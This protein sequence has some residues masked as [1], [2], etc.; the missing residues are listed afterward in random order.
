VPQ[1]GGDDGGD[2]DGDETRRFFRAPR[3]VTHLRDARSH[4]RQS[5]RR[6][7]WPIRVFSAACMLCACCAT[8]GE[9]RRMK[10]RRTYIL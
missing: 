4:L 5:Y 1:D 8:A 10:S 3:P 7:A 2:D 6:A 9:P